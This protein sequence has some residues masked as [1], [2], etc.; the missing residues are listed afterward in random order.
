M[1]MK[2]LFL[3]RTLSTVN[4]LIVNEVDQKPPFQVPKCN[5]YYSPFLAILFYSPLQNLG[6]RFFS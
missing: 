2:K 4:V 5:F 3:S 6:K 1:I